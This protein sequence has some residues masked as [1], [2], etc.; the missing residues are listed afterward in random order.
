[1]CNVQRCRSAS[2]H[3][4]CSSASKPHSEHSR[5]SL[6]APE[7]APKALQ[8]AHKTV[9]DD[10]LDHIPSKRLPKS[11]NTIKPLQKYQKKI[12]PWRYNG[13]APPRS[14][15]PD[16]LPRLIEINI[17]TGRL[18]SNEFHRQGVACGS[19]SEPFQGRMCNVQRCRSASRHLFCSSASKPQ[20]YS[21]IPSTL[22]APKRLQGTLQRPSEASRGSLEAPENAPKALQIVHKTVPDDVLDHIPS[23]KLPKSKNTIK[24]LQKYQKKN[25]PVGVQRLDPATI[26]SPR[27][28]PQTNR[29]QYSYW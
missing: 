6:E 11:K 13:S 8:I 24:T 21:K 22:E 12:R 25:P 20:K 26:P 7:N 29:N 23:K 19:V 5:G 10:V 15:P 27:P 16:P 28:P 3:L 1:M 4:F 17:L 2:R 18:N 14:P 9:P